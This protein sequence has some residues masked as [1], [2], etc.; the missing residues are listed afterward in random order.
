M[1]KKSLVSI[2][3]YEK[4]IESVRKAV[5]LS[6]GLDHLPADAKVFIK[7]NIVFWTKET[8]FPKWGVIT[9]SRVVE[10]VVILLKERGIN[11][12]NIGEGTVLRNP[13]N[14][15]EQIH[16]FDTLGY[17][18][19]KRHYG[20]KYINI[21]ERP[22]EKVDL[23]DGVELKFNADILNSDFVV[24]LPVLKT[25]TMTV[26]S[27]GIKN[28]KGMI[29]I[30]SRK[31]CH[32]TEPGKDLHF[33]VAK[34]ADRMPPM[35]TL[36]DGI[37]TA[38]RGPNIDGR[39][40]RSNLLVASADVLSADMVGARVLG[41]EPSVV[42][43]LVHAAHNHQRQLNLSDVAVVGEPLEAVARP[44]EYDFP[45]NK[46]NTLPLPMEKMGIKGLSYPKYDLSL[47][48][49]CAGLTRIVLMAIASAWQGKAW[50]DVEVLSG[51]VMQPTA[52][53]QKTILFG[54]CIHQ[55]NRENP[56]INEM[57]PIKGCP[58]RPK[59]IVKALHQ[60]GINVDPSLF[61]NID[62]L[63]GFLFKRYENKPEFDESF[64]QIK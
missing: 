62:K 13:K 7:P 21:W 60:A 47:C 1:N 35:L 33:M 36:L 43:H 31:K 58:P 37:Y 4:P 10:D 39:M 45:Y 2:V 22:F 51:K 63:P 3:K 61:E 14:N 15:A 19:L 44:H 23:G 56:D 55:A 16:A 20:V 5:E 25:H 42:P 28:L 17:D 24:D 34:M 40:N 48:T 64:F 49:Y 6:H 41:Y 27:L 26:V 59:S 57:I 29:D 52:G 54:K 53:K 30:P 46:D 50:D 9:T 11:D 32:N 12:I 8:N 18:V 38:E